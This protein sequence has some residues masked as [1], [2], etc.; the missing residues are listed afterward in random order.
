MPF[1]QQLVNKFHPDMWSVW[2]HVFRIS[3]SS[4]MYFVPADC[5]TDNFPFIVAASVMNG[6]QKRDARCIEAHPGLDCHTC[7]F[8]SSEIADT[9]DMIKY[10]K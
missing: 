7:G 9:I 8:S 2:A 10:Q 3:V 5:G 1:S 4:S 6:L